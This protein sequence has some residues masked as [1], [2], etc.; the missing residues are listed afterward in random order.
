MQSQFSEF[1]NTPE[2]GSIRNDEE[3]Q[4]LPEAERK[5]WQELWERWSWS[6]KE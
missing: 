1:W 4:K 2:L 5:R 3:L 6:E